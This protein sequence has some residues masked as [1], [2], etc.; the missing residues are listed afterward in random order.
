MAD[1][2]YG[3]E[4]NYKFMEE[5]DIEAF[6]KYNYFHKEQKKKFKNN[7][8]HADNLYYNTEK[9]YFVCPMGQKMNKIGEFVRKSDLGFQSQIS[10]YKAQR[11]EGCPLRGLCHKAQENRKIE[12]NHKLRSYKAKARERLLSEEGIK[13]RG[14]RSIEPEAVFGQLKSNNNFNRLRLRGLRK[15][16]IDLGLASIGHNLRKMAQKIAKRPSKT[17]SKLFIKDKIFYKIAARDLKDTSHR[18]I[19]QKGLI[20]YLKVQLL[21]AA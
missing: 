2:G 6:V 10:V 19:K 8:F 20:T 7:P 5:N 13:L 4:Q 11:C 9:D 12:V 21:L 14:Q 18:K 15:V 3:S 16:E 1:A 17:H